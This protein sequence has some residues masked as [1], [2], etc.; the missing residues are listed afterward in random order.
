MYLTRGEQR[1]YRI[2]MTYTGETPAVYH[3]DLD[4]APE[5]ETFEKDIATPVRVIDLAS[6]QSGQATT[7]GRLHVFPNPSLGE[8]TVIFDGDRTVDIE[9]SRLLIFDQ[10]GKVVHEDRIIGQVSTR[11]G[12]LPTGTYIARVDSFSVVFTVIR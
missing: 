6:M 7:A 3:E 1:T 11:I 5:R 9:G 4:I 12:G 8:V 10:L 2:R